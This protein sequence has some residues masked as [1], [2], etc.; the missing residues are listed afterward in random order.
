MQTTR[1]TKGGIVTWDSVDWRAG[2]GAEGSFSSSFSGDKQVD[3]QG[4]K[5]V[6]KIDPFRIYGILTPGLAPN[7]YTNSN[8][9]SGAIVAGQIYNN[10]TMFG[11]SSGGKVY[12]TSSFGNTPSI[13]NAGTFPH[14]IAGSTVV[15]QD[16]LLYAHNSSSIQVVSLFY[17]YY[18][19][20]NWNVGADVNLI[21]GIGTFNDT[22]MST[23]PTQATGPGTVQTAGTTTLVGTN[24]LFLTTLR[25]GDT[26]LV[27]GETVRTVTAIASN[28]SLT[29]GV[30]FST[31]SAG[32]SYTY[33]PN[34]QRQHPHPMGI[35]ADGV[36]YIGS[37]NLLHGYN[38]SV[39]ANGTFY[40][41]VLTF[42]QGFEIIGIRKYN[43]SLLIAG[44][45]SPVGVAQNDGAGE[46]LVYIWNYTDL[47]VTQVVPLEDPYVSAI[48]IYRGN[49]TVI[50]SG[51]QERNGTNKVK[52][53]T[54]ISTT[55]IV[56]FDGVIPIQRG[57]VVAD[58]VLYMNSGGKILAYGDKYNKSNAINHIAT[59]SVSNTSGFLIYNFG[60]TNLTSS[61]DDNASTASLNNFDSAG[62]DA[63][64]LTSF[65]FQL[66]LP[67][68]KRA[69]V[70]SV[71]IQYYQTLDANASNGS[72]AMSLIT[73]FGTTTSLLSGVTSIAT[74][75]IKKYLYT[76][77]GTPLPHCTTLGWSMTFTGPSTTGT[78]FISQV[79]IEYEDA[80]IGSNTII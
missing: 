9:L 46:A 29:V 63:G 73:D 14:T 67:H 33:F 39:G 12:K 59:C 32:L 24:T 26:I 76:A 31:S 40:P 36:L 19:S 65:N 7:A 53:I 58:D 43:D 27:S 44:N 72:L 79:Q 34:S 50:T 35:G 5:R 6:T 1:T 75:L 64:S 71:Q 17:S 55:K 57:I 68:G 16:T 77:A 20:T 80:D 47:N 54:G 22:F 38:G 4:W 74:P 23:I 13:I 78:P 3:A 45:Y 8:L 37:G 48:F 69:R 25:I 70:V 21:S 2:L 51:I 56:D 52:V 42:L 49:P 61:S 30:A 18:N 62:T 28:T 11:I 10:T 60:N 41:S 15:G 66:P